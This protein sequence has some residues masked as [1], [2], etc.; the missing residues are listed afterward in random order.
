M[1]KQDFSCNSVKVGVGGAVQRDKGDI[2]QNT[3]KLLQITNQNEYPL[4][5]LRSNRKFLYESGDF[6]FDERPIH[7]P[8]RSDHNS[9]SLSSLT[10]KRF[11]PVGQVYFF[12]T[13]KATNKT[14]YIMQK[15]IE[16]RER[17]TNWQR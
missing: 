14:I 2:N 10:S 9:Y 3:K 8:K 13:E 1:Q 16:K 11:S 5:L 7:E 12:P 17:K 15:T 6:D 4:E